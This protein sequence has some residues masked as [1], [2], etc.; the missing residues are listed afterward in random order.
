MH[1]ENFEYLIADPFGARLHPGFVQEPSPPAICRY[2]PLHQYSMNGISFGAMGAMGA[3][4]GQ[5]GLPN[6]GSHCGDL[7][8]PGSVSS[9]PSTQTPAGLSG[10]GNGND[11]NSSIPTSQSGGNGL[12]ISK[13]G[14]NGS[15]GSNGEGENSLTGLNGSGPGGSESSMMGPNSVSPPIHIGNNHQMGG[16]GGHVRPQQVRSPYE[17]M[18][19]PSYQSQSSTSSGKYLD[20]LYYVSTG[21]SSSLR[22]WLSFR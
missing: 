22:P 2:T 8:S 3:M 18:K 10:N 21:R 1:S 14:M 7:A 11:H 12:T 19:K 4:Q 16:N 9:G 13:N 17:W 20:S 5:N 15:N 6:S